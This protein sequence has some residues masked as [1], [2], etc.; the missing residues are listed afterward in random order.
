MEENKMQLLKDGT[1]I[2]STNKYKDVKRV[3][4]EYKTNGTLFYPDGTY[5]K[6]MPQK[7]IVSYDNF[8]DGTLC[9][10]N[11]EK[12]IVNVWSKSNYMP[13]YCHYCGQKLKWKYEYI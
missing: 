13:K 10:P 6:E 11:C 5:K 2:V 7:P 1:L 12:P 4:V 3:L 9:C 8:G